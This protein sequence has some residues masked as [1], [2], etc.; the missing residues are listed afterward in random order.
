M[1]LPENIPS[2]VGDPTVD[3]A[4]GVILKT[5]AS[6]L[7]SDEARTHHGRN[8]SGGPASFASSLANQYDEKL[9]AAYGIRAHPA[10][11]PVEVKRLDVDKTKQ[12]LSELK[13]VAIDHQRRYGTNHIVASEAQ[14]AHSHYLSAVSQEL[15]V[16][17]NVLDNSVRLVPISEINESRLSRELREESEQRLLQFKTHDVNSP[18]YQLRLASHK[19]EQH[20]RDEELNV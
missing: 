12:H 19:F 2:L 3:L 14:S 16:S 1:N 10:R 13:S 6:D 9:K 7:Q 5:L 17:K 20:L 18:A 8:I 4:Q 11:Y 15:G